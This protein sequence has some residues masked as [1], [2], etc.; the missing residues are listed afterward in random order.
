MSRNVPARSPSR[1]L[2]CRDCSATVRTLA[3]G[4]PLRLGGDRGREGRLGAW[5][6]SG[7]R[8]DGMRTVITAQGF[9][10]SDTLRESVRTAGGFESMI[11][12][13]VL[14]AEFDAETRYTAGRRPSS[15][16]ACRA[17]RPA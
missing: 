8:S 10:L 12:M 17:A 9:D 13:S 1:S 4:L 5:T 2:P 6:L 15:S 16:S 7:Y 3:V 11:V 14:A